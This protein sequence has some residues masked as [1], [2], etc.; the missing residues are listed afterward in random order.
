MLRV[1]V[2]SSPASAKLLCSGRIV[3]GVESETLR[4]IATA[5]AEPCLILDLGHV[6]AIDGAGLGLLAELH[7]WALQRNR[8]LTIANPSRPV[9]RLL[10]LTNPLAALQISYSAIADAGFEDDYAGDARQAMT[11]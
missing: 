11:A 5:R 3:L 9:W 1:D 4:C 7:C 6:D 2:Q 10:A 8:L